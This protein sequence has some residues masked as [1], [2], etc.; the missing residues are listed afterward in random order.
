M[1]RCSVRAAPPALTSL[2]PSLWTLQHSRPVTFLSSACGRW[3]G[4]KVA[5]SA[6]SVVD[7]TAKV[8]SPAPAPHY[9]SGHDLPCIRRRGRHVERAWPW[10]LPL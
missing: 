8:W 1:H 9:R 5:S 7:A 4:K 2:A 10:W 3:P 6:C